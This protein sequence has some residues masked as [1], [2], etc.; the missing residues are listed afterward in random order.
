[1]CSSLRLSKLAKREIEPPMDDRL[2]K[3]LAQLGFNWQSIGTI[4]NKTLGSFNCVV[5]S[6][7]IL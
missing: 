1:M 7:I 3:R 4:E 2:N 6:L 5:A